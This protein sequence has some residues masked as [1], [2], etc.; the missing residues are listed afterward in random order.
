MM[1]GYGYAPLGNAPG[2]PTTTAQLNISTAASIAQN[3]VSQLN[4]PNLKVAQVEEY[5]QNFYVQIVE[6]NTGVGAF[7]QLINKYTGALSPEPGPNMMWNTKYGMMSTGMMGLY[8][9][10]PTATM[11]VNATQAAANA[12][13]YLNSYYAGTKVGDVTTFYGYFTIEVL[14]GGTTYGMISVNG[15]TGQVWYHTWHGTFIA[16]QQVS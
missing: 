11:P 8:A 6:K 10:A 4:D 7:E 9:T 15:Y 13:Q 3:Y 12:Q 5:T 2:N 14:Q 16:E 1:A